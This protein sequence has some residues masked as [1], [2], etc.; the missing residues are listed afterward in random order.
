MES[1][2]TGFVHNTIQLGV[3][4][5]TSLT[6]SILKQ[7]SGACIMCV[8][9]F[10]LHNDEQTGHLLNIYICIHKYISNEWCAHYKVLYV[11]LENISKR[12]TNVQIIWWVPNLN[13]IG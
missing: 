2:Q 10:I 11:C 7:F 13:L 4:A 1:C 5:R 6:D 9:Y 3:Y 8:Q 12:I